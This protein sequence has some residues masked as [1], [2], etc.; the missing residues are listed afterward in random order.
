MTQEYCDRCDGCGW[1]EGGA[2]LNT[3][4]EKCGGSGVITSAPALAA[5]APEA[6]TPCDHCWHQY[7]AASGTITMTGGSHRATERCCFCGETK[8]VN[9]TWEHAKPRGH[10][11]YFHE[12]E[13]F[14]K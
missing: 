10:G 4:C 13:A 3:T 12:I 14:P 7:G 11:P 8:Q 5:P 6:A 2:T 9:L 1:Y